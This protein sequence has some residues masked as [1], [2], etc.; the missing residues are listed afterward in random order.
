MCIYIYRER[1]RET[2][3]DREREREIHFIVKKSVYWIQKAATDEAMVEDAAQAEE[4]TVEEDLGATQR[5]P[6][7]RIQI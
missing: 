7:P 6:T 1:E 2:Y 3:G 5:D 4:E